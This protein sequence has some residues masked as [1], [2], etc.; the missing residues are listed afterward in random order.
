M[1][2]NYQLSRIHNYVMGL[3]SKEE[4]YALERE[5]L[6]DPFLQDAIDGYRLQRGVDAK[7]VSLLQKRL[8]E[9]VDRRALEKNRHFYNWQRL[10][11]GMVAGVLFV[12][13]CSLVLFKYFGNANK[14]G[15]TEVILMEEDLR[16]KI[17][18]GGDAKPIQGWELFSEELNSELRDHRHKHL[19]EVS[20]DVQKGQAVNV[21]IT[22]PKHEEALA[23]TVVKFIQDKTKWEGAK[24]QM[25]ISL[26][27]NN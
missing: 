24:G 14:D 21:Q 16:I 23:R 4:M 17:N 11:V 26:S 18:A 15:M 27:K 20:F 7:Q 22:N 9:R 1:E 13:V 6:E 8:L 12:V 25:S 2:N 19:M 10:A 5:A 3:M